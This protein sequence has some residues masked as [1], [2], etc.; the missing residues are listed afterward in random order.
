MISQLIKCILFFWYSLYSF[1]FSCDKFYLTFLWVISKGNSFFYHEP[2]RAFL[3][4]QCLALH[5]LCRSFWRRLPRFI[6]PGTVISP[7]VS[8]S[9]S[10]FKRLILWPEAKATSFLYIPTMFSSLFWAGWWARTVALL[11]T[12]SSWWASRISPAWKRYSS[13]LFWHHTSWLWW[14]TQSSFWSLPLTLISKHPCTF[15]SPTSP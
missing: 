3:S 12:T 10:N 2:S 4:V 13:G 14:E 15:S 9:K 5:V 7:R 1:I 11:K 8:A 6:L